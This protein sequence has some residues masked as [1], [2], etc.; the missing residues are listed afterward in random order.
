MSDFLILPPAREV[1]GTV[2]A[3]PS[4]SG[5]NRALLLAA[6]SPRVVHVLRPL[7]SED[8]RALVRCL[9]AMGASVEPEPGGLAVSG[10]LGVAADREVELDA[11][12]SGTAARFLTAVCAVT[13]GKFLLTGAPRLRERPITALVTSL[14]AAG[15]RI[16]YRGGQ[17]LPLAIEGATLSSRSVTVDASQSSQ[18]VS[19]LLLAGA[20][21]EGGLAIR[22]EGLVASSP[23]VSTTVES[24]RAFGHIVEIAG[25]GAHVVRPGRDPVDRYEVT[26]DFSSALPLLA[27]AGVAGGEVAVEGL[28]WPSADADA[29]AFTRLKEFGLEIAAGPKRIRVSR[30]DGLKPAVL[31]ATDFPDAVPT[32]AVLA[33]FAPGLSRFEGI[34][35]LRWKESDRIEALVRL[36]E[37]AGIR[38]HGETGSISVEGTASPIGLGGVR[39]L[40][41]FGDH[42]VAMAG[43]LLSL[44]IPDL[45]IENPACVAKSYPDFFRDLESVV[46]R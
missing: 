19:A 33:A 28:A 13:R 21:S 7:D 31:R 16:S 30:V 24:L 10:P 42:R 25:D 38:A 6:L 8:T 45:A 36:F 18:F 1:R 4:K 15:A 5:T 27:A 14:S 9:G 32:L 34:G 17:G 23:Y 37:G 35:H 12:E 29:L 43:A 22:T 3:P 20:A 46:Q 2:A 39:R 41:T 26:G 44:R 11:G 40:P